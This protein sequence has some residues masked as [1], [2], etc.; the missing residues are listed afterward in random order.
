MNRKLAWVAVLAFMGVAMFAI[1][2]I[3]SVR[4]ETD[5]FSPEEPIVPEH[6]VDANGTVFQ[7]TNSSFLNVNLT[8]SEFVHVFLESS[9]RVVSYGIESLSSAT[10][11]TLTLSGFIP[12]TTYYRYQDGNLTENFITDSVGGYS[13]VQDI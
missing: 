6:F 2:I 7:I 11:T 4:A 9:P 3:P 5:P 8:S 1:Q 13:Y 12:H 10:S